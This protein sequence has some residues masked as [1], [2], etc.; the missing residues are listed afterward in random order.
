MAVIG[1]HPFCVTLFFTFQTE[2]HLYIVMEYLP[3]GHL[4][5]YVMDSDD[6]WPD[7]KSA[8]YGGEVLL[9]LEHM[10]N[11]NVV[12]RD[13]KLENILLDMDGHVRLTDFGLS[14]LL[15]DRGDR[16]HSMSGTAAYIAPEV[17]DADIG[18]SFSADLWSF[19]V[20]MFILLLHESPFYA[21]NTNE[22]F[23]MIR[24][25]EI[26]WED[27]E[28]ELSP[29]AMSLLQGLL[30]KSVDRRLGCG[31]TGIEEVKAHPF[32]AG[33]DWEAM[34][35]MEVKPHIRPKLRVAERA[36][37]EEFKKEIEGAGLVEG[38]DP[39]GGFSFVAAD[40][41][42]LL[43]EDT[44]SHNTVTEEEES[45]CWP[46]PVNL[47]PISIVYRIIGYLSIDDV[48]TAAHVCKDWNTLLWSRLHVMDFSNVDPGL[49]SKY[50]TSKIC[51]LLSRPDHLRSLT[52]NQGL[53]DAG[54]SKLPQI[55]SLETLSLSGCTN[56][57]AHAIQRLHRTVQVLGFGFGKKEKE[58][59]KE[60][61]SQF[62]T[63]RFP[64]L[65]KLIL[66]GC[67]NIGDGGLEHVANCNSLQHLDLSGVTSITDNGMQY[68]ALLKKLESVN[69]SGVENI[70]DAGLVHLHKL[71]QLRKVDLGGTSVTE[72]GVAALRELRKG[73]DVVFSDYTADQS[74]KKGKKKQK[75]GLAFMR[76]VSLTKKPKRG[77]KRA[78]SVDVSPGGFDPEFLKAEA[79]SKRKPKSKK[80]P[81]DPLSP[82]ESRRKKKAKSRKDSDAES[83]EQAAAQA[84]AKAAKTSPT[85][86]DT[87][88]TKSRLRRVPSDP[89]DHDEEKRAR[90]ERKREK[91][92][93][94]KRERKEKMH[95]AEEEAGK[96]DG[97]PASDAAEREAE[98]ATRKEEETAKKAEKEAK[99]KEKAAKAEAERK[100][101]EEEEQ[102]AKEEAERKAKEEEE[103][104]KAKEEQERTA[105]EEA[106]C[107]AKEEAEHK[108]KEEEEARAKEADS[109]KLRKANELQQKL[110]RQIQSD[111]KTEEPDVA[112]NARNLWRERDKASSSSTLPLKPAQARSGVSPRASSVATVER[113]PRAGAKA[114]APKG[115]AASAAG[116]PKAAAAVPKAAAAVPKA[117]A[118]AKATPPRTAGPAVS[119]PKKARVRVSAN[120]K[121]APKPA[122]SSPEAEAAESAEILLR[123]KPSRARHVARTG[124]RRSVSDIA[125][126]FVQKE[127]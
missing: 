119:A 120:A 53:K 42:G 81:G 56:L 125:A 118:T 84:S 35:R 65:S 79:D 68:V 37:P 80:A 64:F 3:G 16:V 85:E 97:T 92:E 82:R 26:A 39:F 95:K 103:E 73:I 60:K 6:A 34:L 27:F 71:P 1:D 107:K 117:A 19:G 31:P 36:T 14:A 101:R 38:E 55:I 8:F 74:K 75:F 127:P 17:L 123:S 47:L 20:M 43:Q 52:L 15:K 57:S 23:E 18:H 25:Q 2:T 22:L 5:S 88:K 99:K 83:S 21:E 108:A 105:K 30:T 116:G 33:I 59:K 115:A 32:F 40:Y 28:G 48:A 93:T 86:A 24:T 113:G 50:W 70:T 89:V 76:E 122:A 12:Y 51:P 100:A 90:K 46:F 58:K 9:A 72:A 78:T 104:Q 121:D 98:E 126:I 69:L 112:A 13:L 114:T 66:R 49:F 111:E 96:A 29:N 110:R 4:L 62:G 87:K 124:A 63:Q 10:H 91:D 54:I 61:A 41:V 11:S 67:A 44:T 109:E 45:V 7:D 77:H 94:R 102:K 106:E